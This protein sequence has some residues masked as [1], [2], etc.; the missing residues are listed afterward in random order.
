MT[1]ARKL[2]S[3]LKQFINFRQGRLN[4]R[5]YIREQQ[6]VRDTLSRGFA[7]KLALELN[8]TIDQSK[9][10]LENQVIPEISIL[11][12][13]NNNAISGTIAEYAR[14]TYRAIF[15]LNF[16]K[17][18]RVLQKQ[19]G[20]PLDFGRSAIFE[21]AVRA[22]L[23]TRDPLIT[24]ISRNMAERI[25][26]HIL[27]ERL[28]DKTLPQIAAGISNKFSGI[29]RSRANVIA[30]TETHSAAGYA[31]HD[32][33]EQA[34]DSYG[35]KMI[36]QWVST[37]DARTRQAHVIMNGSKVDMNEDFL[38]PNGARMSFC[39]D[40]KG[41]AANVVNC[42]CVTLYHDPEDFVSD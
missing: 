37:S 35:L 18:D 39:G 20:D 40:A 32:Y 38:M 27:D 14:K 4:A 41:G 16:E 5:K 19:E 24:N 2:I 8:K 28:A 17:Y 10:S 12:Q 13:S 26:N 25:I 30:R 36:K 33:H 31:N 3:G 22:Y 21:N 7:K 23:L 6:R 15:E 34:S 29:N 42:R 11:I 1:A 9:V